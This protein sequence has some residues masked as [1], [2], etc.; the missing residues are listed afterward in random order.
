MG[1]EWT[2]SSF[3]EELG[4]NKSSERTFARFMRLREWHPNSTKIYSAPKTRF[5]D[6]NGPV[7]ETYELRIDEAGFIWPSII[8]DKPDAEIV[9]LG[10]S[11]TES[12]YIRPKMRFPYLVGRQIE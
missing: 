1:V 3:H 7:D 10:G 2:L 9:F 4:I 8:H 12:L 11:T 5:N 6:P